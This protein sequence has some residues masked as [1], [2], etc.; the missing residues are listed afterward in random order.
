MNN[1]IYFDNNATTKVAPEVLEAMMPFFTEAYGNP[2]SMHKFGG[3]VAEHI[4]EARKSVASLINAKPDEIYFVSCGTEGDNAA[5]FSAM[6]TQP[7]KRHLI[8][9]PVEHSAVVASMKKLEK[10]GYDVTYL[11]VDSK[12]RLDMEEIRSSIRPD[13]GL[14]S[15]MWANNE[16]GNIYPIKEITS[17]AKEHGIQMHT[18][19]VQAVGKI[20]IDVQENPVDYLVCSGHKLHAPKGIGVLFIK[21]GTRFHP[22]ITGGQQ[23]KGK[24]A[25][26]ENIPY[27]VGLGKAAQFAQDNI[28]KE[29]TYVKS[30]RDTL[31]QGIC[32]TI[33]DAIINGDTENRLPNTTNI[34]F[35]NV[36]GE[37]ILLL[38]D[39]H[40]IC[41][42]SGSACTSGSLD[43]SHVLRAMDVPFN[44]AHGSIRF[45]LSIYNTKEEVEKTV[46][47]L[48]QIIDRLRA[49][50]PFKE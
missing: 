5:I 31:E 29:N 20:P 50:S 17:L 9:T 47:V 46:T 37:A 33:K 21:K 14:I 3:T 42:S 24:R 18:D 30:L 12:G 25:G 32:S 38:L 36:E 49:I 48:P 4:R 40:G 8:T 10:A 13:T 23:E 34:S 1:V 2:S 41:A 11:H 45:S 16:T 7:Q 27:I 26:T 15:I 19:A 6:S 44:Y 28:E 39:S 22:L 35:K 43:P